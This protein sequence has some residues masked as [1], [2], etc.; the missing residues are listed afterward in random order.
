M[1]LILIKLCSGKINIKVLLNSDF[2]NKIF[3]DLNVRYC[4][5]KNVKYFKI[6]VV[7]W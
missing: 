1:Y 6:F 4:L 3:G 2:N 7:I 5:C